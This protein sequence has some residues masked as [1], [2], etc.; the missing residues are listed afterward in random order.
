MS[1]L[2]ENQIIAILEKKIDALRNVVEIARHCVRDERHMFPE[3]PPRWT[4]CGCAG[5]NTEHLANALRD[6]ELDHGL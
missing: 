2:L 1:D 6:L 4:D 3:E 5:P